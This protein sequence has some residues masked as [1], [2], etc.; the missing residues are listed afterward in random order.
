MTG[1]Q[2]LGLPLLDPP[3]A[4]KARNER[5]RSS[6]KTISETELPARLCP[7]DIDKLRPF[8]ELPEVGGLSDGNRSEERWLCGFALAK[9]LIRG[10]KTAALTA[11]EDNRMSLPN[12]RLLREIP[13]IDLTPNRW[14]W[15][16]GD[17]PC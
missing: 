12:R 14:V 9:G 2:W 6:S 3:L 7:Q 1:Y 17:A 16:G 13:S 11:L 15:L 5:L 10:L 8:L 4:P